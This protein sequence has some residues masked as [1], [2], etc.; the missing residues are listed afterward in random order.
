MDKSPHCALSG[1]GALEFARSIN[2]DETV[3]PEELRGD[4]PYQQIKNVTSK[5]FDGFAGV[6]F[7]G[8]Q[9][10][11]ADQQPAHDNAGAETAG[12]VEKR[13]DEKPHD[14]VGAVAIDREGF[15]ACANSTGIDTLASHFVNT[16]S[17]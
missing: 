2:F 11:C 15:L 14:T 9:V 16:I 7:A 17:D 5:N 4:Y 13:G 8:K 3:D 10:Q 6:I 1:E 12:V